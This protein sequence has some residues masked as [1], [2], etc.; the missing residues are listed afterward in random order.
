MGQVQVG[1]RDACRKPD[2]VPRKP[3]TVDGESLELLTPIEVIPEFPVFDLN[4][5]NGSMHRSLVQYY[6]LCKDTSIMVTTSC[7][8]I[9]K[10]SQKTNGHGKVIPAVPAH[11]EEG[12][13]VF[14]FD[15]NINLVGGSKDMDG[16]CNLRDIC[17]EE[18]VDF[19]E[20]SNGFVCDSCYRH[21]FIHHSSVYCNVLVQANILDAVVNEDYFSSIIARYSEPEEKII[22]IVDVNGTLVWDDR[23]SGIGESAVLL[24]TMFGFAE[25][26]PREPCEFMWESQPPVKLAA[27][28]NL[29]KLVKDIY[30]EDND[31]SLFFWNCMTCARFLHELSKVVDIGW[32][33]Q[34]LL[35]SSENFLY[36]FEA[37]MAD[38]RQ[39]VADDGIAG[40]WLKAYDK[41]IASGHSVVLNSFGVDAQRVLARLVGDTREVTQVV[42]NYDMWSEQDVRRFKG[43]VGRNFPTEDAFETVPSMVRS[44]VSRLS[45]TFG[46]TDAS[47]IACSTSSVTPALTPNATPR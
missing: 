15:D 6:V 47:M 9:W 5:Y 21:T 46:V 31:S 34:Q 19:T 37:N 36:Q 17:T 11:L 7:H 18:Y 30:G 27:R 2:H 8:E 41:L 14:F 13:R 10:N 33:K 40:S 24:R 12:V 42:V 20:R 16:I 26:R 23:T 38:I 35:F 4:F 22:V 1:C 44:T 32:E 28:Q 25:V 39:Y 29:R 3:P 45:L 43:E